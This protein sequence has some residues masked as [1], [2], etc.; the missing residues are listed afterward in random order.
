MNARG[1][2]REQGKQM[3]LFGS[4]LIVASLRVGLNVTVKGIPA[5]FSFST[6][7]SVT[8][9]ISLRVGAVALA[10]LETA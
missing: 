8:P 10:G 5:I 3:I 7:H 2:T 4:W 9:Q 6:T 1:M